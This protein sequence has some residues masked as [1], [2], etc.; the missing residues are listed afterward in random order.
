[1][2]LHRPSR[3]EIGELFRQSA[4]FVCPSWEEGVGMPSLEAMAC[5]AALATTDTKGSRDYATHGR[6]AL[7][8]PPRQP[9]RLAESILALLGDVPLRQRL[10][11]AALRLVPRLYRPWPE[12]AAAFARA[13]LPTARARLR[14]RRSSSRV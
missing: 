4:V 1:R 3:A 10:S 6:T 2:F 5:G 8:T 9:G 11:N 12:A 14:L 13:V 7:V